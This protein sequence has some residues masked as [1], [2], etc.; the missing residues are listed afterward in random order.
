M[1]V[2][3]KEGQRGLSRGGLNKGLNPVV[4]KGGK[5]E[6]KSAVNRDW[7]PHVSLLFPNSGL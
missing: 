3:N 1:T 2:S 4:W 5:Q 7:P 6:Y